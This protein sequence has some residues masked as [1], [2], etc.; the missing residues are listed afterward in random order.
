MDDK[1]IDNQIEWIKKYFDAEV[2]SIREAV[3]KV[4][5]TN[6]AKF[7]AQN[8]W[9]QQFKDQTSTFLTRREMIIVTLAIIGF[10]ITILLY[11]K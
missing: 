8:E 1:Y 4:E 7:E 11:K 6:R 5:A 3:D 2:K 9:R 10:L